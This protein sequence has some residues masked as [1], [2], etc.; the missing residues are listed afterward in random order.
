MFKIIS[1]LLRIEK[2]KTTWKFNNR[3]EL[4]KLMLK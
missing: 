2:R 4:K 3:G 1:M